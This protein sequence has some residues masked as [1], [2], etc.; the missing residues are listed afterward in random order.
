MKFLNKLYTKA[1]FSDA[2]ELNLSAYDLGEDM[3]SATLDDEVVTRLKTATGS[4]GSLAIVVGVSVNVAILKTSPVIQEY[5]KRILENAYLGG[6]LT[7]TDDTKQ[8]FTLR[9]IS[10]NI[11]EIPAGN[12]TSPATTFVING[13][14][15]VN[16]KA[17]I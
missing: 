6:T 10:L 7:I 14:L 5:Y 12:G 9:D 2:T 17:L 13:N 3:I 16:Q 4:V 11:S 15:V 1:N 8:S